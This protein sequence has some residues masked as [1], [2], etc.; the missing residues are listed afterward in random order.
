MPPRIISEDPRIADAIPE[1]VYDEMRISRLRFVDNHLT[2]TLDRVSADGELDPLSNEINLKFRG[3]D[4]VLR[5]RIS[6][7]AAWDALLSELALLY[8]E[9]CRADKLPPNSEFNHA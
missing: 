2:L 1:K 6:L 9:Q 7:G 4:A 5:Q 3:F 8:H